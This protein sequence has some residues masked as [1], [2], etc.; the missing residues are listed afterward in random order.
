MPSPIRSVTQSIDQGPNESE[1]GIPR[2][3]DECPKAYEYES[4]G[5]KAFCSVQ[6]QW[7]Q[8]ICTGRGSPNMNGFQYGVCTVEIV[9]KEL[10]IAIVVRHSESGYI[11]PC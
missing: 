3:T 11:H 2:V 10:R 6:T 7:I 1:I 4:R 9:I 8:K 5:V